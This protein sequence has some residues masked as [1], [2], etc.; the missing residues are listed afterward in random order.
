MIYG[1]SNGWRIWRCFA[2]AGAK[3]HDNANRTNGPPADE[4]GH[5]FILPWVE[6]DSFVQGEMVCRIRNSLG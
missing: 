6:W 3:F 2:L 4:I 5:Y 1:E